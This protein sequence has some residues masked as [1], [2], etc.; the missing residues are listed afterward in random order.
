MAGGESCTLAICNPTLFR[1]WATFHFVNGHMDDKDIDQ[2][3]M[4]RT[5]CTLCLSLRK[6]LLRLGNFHCFCREYCRAKVWMA[7][8]ITLQD[9]NLQPLRWIRNALPSELNVCKPQ[10]CRSP[11][12][13]E[14]WE[15]N[16]ISPAYEADVVWSSFEAH[17]VPLHRNYDRSCSGF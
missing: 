2:Q 3:E 14:W 7:I 9:L 17:S 11:L 12:I 5:C 1:P 16:P 10:S 15:S 8:K 6:L 13:S 4:S